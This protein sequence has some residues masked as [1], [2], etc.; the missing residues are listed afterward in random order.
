MALTG[1]RE[2]VHCAPVTPDAIGVGIAGYGLAGRVFH[3]V[4]VQRT[5]GLRLRAVCSRTAR[6][7]QAQGEHAGSPS[8]SATRPA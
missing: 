4:L 3:A 7:E 8:T 2:G 6:R 5:P 1:H